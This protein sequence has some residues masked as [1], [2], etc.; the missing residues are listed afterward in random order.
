M[1]LTQ[2]MGEFNL[3]WRILKKLSCSVNYEGTFE[4][5]RNYNLIYANITQRF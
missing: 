2:N 1:A 4:K 5:A 3:T